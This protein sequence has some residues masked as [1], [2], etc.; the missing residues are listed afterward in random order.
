M[1]SNVS[2]GNNGMTGEDYNQNDMESGIKD[3][4]VH[5]VKKCM[6]NNGEFNECGWKTNRY[7]ETLING[8]TNAEFNARMGVKPLPERPQ[9]TVEA[10]RDGKIVL[11]GETNAEFNKR[12]QSL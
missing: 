1:S 7:G 6:L 11:N 8:E 2:S 5:I 3:G 4:K 10:N 12:I 9:P